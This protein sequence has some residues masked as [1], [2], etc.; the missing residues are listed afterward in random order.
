VVAVAFCVGVGACMVELPPRPRPPNAPA[1]DPDL[2][3]AISTRTLDNGL[4]VV[5]V[6]DPTATDVQVTMRYAVGASSDGPT[7]GI[8]H[9]VEHLM[10]QQ[11]LGR[12]PVFARLEDL[13][14]YFNA[15]TT[16]D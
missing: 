3:L 2:R 10:F 1:R 7:P 13:T 8:A 16:F 14:T 5:V 15:G 12:Q 6:R 4:R 9:L 11:D